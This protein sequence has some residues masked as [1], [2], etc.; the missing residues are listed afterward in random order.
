MDI[1]TYIKNNLKDC[2]EKDITDT[3]LSSVNT[4]DE[5]ILPGLG[6]LFEVYWNNTNDENRKNIVN[7]LYQY[8]KRA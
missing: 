6:V 3:I 4:E 2:N 5:V 8:I 1:R 7:T